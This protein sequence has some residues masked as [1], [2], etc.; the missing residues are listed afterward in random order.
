MCVVSYQLMFLLINLRMEKTILI[1]EAKEQDA[2]RILDSA[3][4]ALINAPYMLS[5]VEDVWSVSMLFK[6]R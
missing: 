3:S 1:R 5:T 6:K 2:E 4:K